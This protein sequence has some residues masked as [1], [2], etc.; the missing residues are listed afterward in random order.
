MALSSVVAG[1]ETLSA[2]ELMTRRVGLTRMRLAIAPVLLFSAARYAPAQGAWSLSLF[3]DPFPS[4]YASDWETNPNISSLTIASPSATAVEVR[5]AYQVTDTRGR[6]L[7]SGA[8]DPLGIPPGAPTV[9]TSIIDIAGASRRDQVL[10]DQMQ[11]TGR[12]PEGTYRACVVMASTNGLVLGE[13]CDSFT[14]VYPDAPQLIAPAPDENLTSQSPIFQWTP[15]QVPPAYQ[16][17]YVLQVAEVLKNQTSE[18][19]LNS[20][21]VHYQQPDLSLTNLQYPADAQPFEPGKRYAWRVVAIDQNGFVPS[22]NGGLSEIR[23]FTFESSPGIRSDI[24]LSLSNDFEEDTRP[25]TPAGTIDI[26]A[27]CSN[28]KKSPLNIEI[29]SAS[30]LGLRR[31]TNQPYVL[32]RDTTDSRWWLATKNARNARAVVVAGDCQGK[33]ATPT[34]VLWIA[35]RDSAV[36]ANITRRMANR[37]VGPDSIHG[38]V[39]I[40]RHPEGPAEAPPGFTEAEEFFGGRSLDIKRGLNF[41]MLLSLRE[42]GLWPWFQRLGFRDREIE[43]KG[44]IGWDATWSIGIAGG[45][46]GGVDVSTERKFFVITGEYPKRSSLETVVETTSTGDKGGGGG[47]SGEGGGGGGGGSGGG[48]GGRGGGGGGGAGAE[49][50]DTT[51]VQAKWWRSMGLAVEVSL[52]DSLGRVW[53]LDEHWKK[54]R[55]DNAYSLDLV[56]KLIHTIEVNDELSLVGYFGLDVAYSAK[57]GPAKEVLDRWDALR[58]ARRDAASWLRD[59]DRMLKRI[60]GWIAGKIYPTTSEL[61]DPE[62]GLDMVFGYGAEGRIASAGG[63]EGTFARIEAINVDGKY[64]IADEELE[65]VVSVTAGF[66][67]VEGAVKLGGSKKWYLGEKPDTL[68]LEKEALDAKLALKDAIMAHSGEL[69]DCG[70]FRDRSSKVCVAARVRAKADKEVEDAKNQTWRLHL[71]AGHM[72]LGD[73]F[74]LLKNL[75]GS[76]GQ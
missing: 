58:S 11:R 55:E 49:T 12:I 7:A 57:R 19:A 22:A 51:V 76:I 30:P 40:V 28:F 64:S 2:E 4:P 35:S 24:T 16:V 26:A 33:L 41:S 54:K 45:A 13:D 69:P 42:W 15:I 17:E 44:F 50:P 61:L 1:V 67:E 48:G 73:A 38:F 25:L 20:S 39:V 3:V 32:W 74:K 6:I 29:T 52:G 60:D 59:K 70:G 71:S 27:L 63:P 8:S 23:T 14:I 68:K 18:E 10:W 36:Q 72:P 37:S 9:L 56:G 62:I 31:F 21:I 65:L 53:S 75:L 5:L 47:G 46:D 43:L 66:G 34:R